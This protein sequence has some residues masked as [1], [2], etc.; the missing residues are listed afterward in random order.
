ME[1]QEHSEKRIHRDDD[2]IE[3]SGDVKFISTPQGLDLED[4]ESRTL[5]E[6]N[7]GGWRVEVQVLVDNEWYVS[8]RYWLP[9]HPS[10]D[11]KYTSLEEPVKMTQRLF[12]GLPTWQ[13]LLLAPIYGILI[14]Y[15]CVSGKD[16][17]LDILED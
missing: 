1:I 9:S 17:S 8:N 7:E 6:Y 3:P 16:V 14:M 5:T 12:T 2:M 11:V 4:F 15:Y 13:R 10:S